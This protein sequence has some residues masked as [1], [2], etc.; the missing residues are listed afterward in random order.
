MKIGHII[1]SIRNKRE[2][3]LEQ[4][5]FDINVATST[6]SRIELGKRSPSIELLE[7]IAVH[8]VVPISDIFRAAEG[9][10]ITLVDSD[11][12]KLPLIEFTEESIQLMTEIQGAS[13]KNTRLITELAKVIN[14][15]LGGSR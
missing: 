11:T 4:M 10:P 8:L 14:K 15:E 1:K 6:L 7:R 9:H 12:K 3:T 13:A 2:R 5:A